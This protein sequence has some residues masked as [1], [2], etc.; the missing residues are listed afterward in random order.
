MLS[1][2]CYNI[3]KKFLKD[4]LLINVKGGVK[5]ATKSILKNINI[6]SRKTSTS[7]VNALENASKKGTKKIEYSRG[8]SAASS[9]DIRKIFG[10]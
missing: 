1:V 4:F 5:M 10:D 3:I 6:K 2:M 8:I 7:L 9:E